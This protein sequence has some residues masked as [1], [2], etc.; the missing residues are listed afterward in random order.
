MI[1]TNFKKIRIMNNIHVLITRSNYDRKDVAA[2]V[3][4]SVQMLHNYINDKCQIPPSVQEGIANFLG[5][6]VDDLGIELSMEEVKAMEMR[7]KYAKVKARYDAIQA[8]L[9]SITYRHPDYGNLIGERTALEHQMMHMEKNYEKYCSISAEDTIDVR[10]EAKSEDEP[11]PMRIRRAYDLFGERIVPK[12]EIQS[13]RYFGNKFS[14]N[15]FIR[16]TIM[17]ECGEFDSFADLFGG[18]GAVSAAFT[19]KKLI[20][21]D[22]LYSNYLS[23][24]TWFSGL[25]YDKDK[26][27]DYIDLFNSLRTEE[28]NYMTE[29]FAGTF[30]THTNCSRI[31]YIRQR[32]ED[33]YYAGELNDMERAMLITSLIYAMDKVSNTTGHYDGYCKV[34]RDRHPIQMGFPTPL[35]SEPG[36]SCNNM[37]VEDIA[38]PMFKC[39]VVY[40]DPPY[41]SRQYANMYNLLENVARWQKPP[42]KG[43]G[44][45]MDV[46]ALSSDFSTV[47]APEAF[48]RLIKG[49]SNVKHIVVSYNNIGQQ[50]H[51]R[52]N[53][54]ITD[55]QMIATL[56]SVGS[57][58]VYSKKF[59]SYSATPGKYR[60]NN[61]ERLFVCHVG[62]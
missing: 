25:P 60:R 24:M 49:L 55:E 28:E 18:T 16:T 17:Q 27:M 13:R 2:A 29:N 43:I 6:T 10:D 47:K 61:E 51:S 15:P 22:M 8:R 57:V 14:L 20:T 32:I 19:D 52:S 54:K 1:G 38:N 21:N 26:V 35:V 9:N 41:N 53:A 59:K 58:K 23:H 30:F 56:E 44:S 5:V 62:K 34:V 7:E 45:Q 37:R 12:V 11:S 4:V 39:D 46:S 3:G 31:G 40:L 33:D 50:G 48:E 42:V 36:N